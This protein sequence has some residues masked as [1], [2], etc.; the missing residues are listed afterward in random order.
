MIKPISFG[1]YKSVL[2]TEW[3]KGNMPSVT[4][5]IYGDTLIKG[6]ETIEHI[7]PKSKGGK[8]T[9][10]N[11]ALANA[12]NNIKRSNY[13]LGIFTNPDIIKGYL[14]QFEGLKLPKFNGDDYIRSLTRT[15]KKIGI[16]L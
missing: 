2:K 9:L 13:D 6:K 12:E 16:N 14:K 15:L 1:S 3:R 10:S 8:S 11:Y 4:K 7:I 5:D